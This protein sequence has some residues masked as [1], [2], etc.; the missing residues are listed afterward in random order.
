MGKIM[1]LPGSI[2][3]L[4]IIALIMLISAC[5][6]KTVYNQLDTLIPVYIEGMVSLDDALEDVLEQRTEVLLSWHRRTQLI[7]YADWLQEMQDDVHQGITINEIRQHASKL[8]TFWHSIVLKLNEE[9]VILLPLLDNNHRQEL[10]ESIDEKNADY[11]NDYIDISDT[12]KIEQFSDRMVDSYENWLGDLDDV[13]LTLIH[14]TAAQLQSHASMKLQQR[15]E[16]QL[17]I[18]IILE[19]PASDKQKAHELREFF[20]QFGK[21]I[22]ETRQKAN[23]RN[24]ELLIELTFNI[25]NRLSEDQSNYLMA[26]TSDFI[27]MLT[28]LSENR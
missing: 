28:E 19:K 13:Q 11:K 15:I 10:F 8:E 17:Q 26:K 25:V 21:H 7:Q 5:S 16:W 4:I 1:H 9:M 24:Q 2:R 27:R 22:R 12:E 20:D 18:S 14:E 23:Q 3:T 6:F